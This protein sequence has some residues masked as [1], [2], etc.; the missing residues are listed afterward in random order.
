MAVQGVLIYCSSRLAWVRLKRTVL[1]A[2]MPAQTVCF[3]SN[4]EC[5]D[6]NGVAPG[7]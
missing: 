3:L 2:L 6:I 5:S 4:F 1:I 7:T